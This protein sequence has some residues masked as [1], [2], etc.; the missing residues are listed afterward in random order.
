MV[1]YAFRVALRARPLRSGASTVRGR[2]TR[3]VAADVEGGN[4]KRLARIPDQPRRLHDSG[5]QGQ[6]H[7]INLSRILFF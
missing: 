2:A 1:T 6:H 7:Y 3:V 5:Q 4:A